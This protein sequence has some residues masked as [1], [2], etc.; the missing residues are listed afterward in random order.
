MP[1]KQ[2][3]MGWGLGALLAL[4]L[5]G[6][7]GGLVPATPTAPSL[8]DPIT[9]QATA[10][11]TLGFLQARAILIY[12]QNGWVHITEAVTHDLDRDLYTTLADGTPVP[13]NHVLDTWANITGARLVT[14]QV[15]FLH[16]EAGQLLQTSV[17]SEGKKWNSATQT[18]ESTD[19]GP[20]GAFDRG[21]GASIPDYVRAGAA[22]SQTAG[23]LDGAATIEIVVDYSFDK[24]SKYED[25]T[26][27]VAGQFIRAIYDPM[28]GQL[29]QLNWH[30][31]LADG[32][33][34]AYGVWN[35]TLEANVSPP[36]EVLEAL[37]VIG[38]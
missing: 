6:C 29:R 18:T 7:G 11:E 34:R 38:P 23:T 28:G 20:A 27:E 24:P 19:S 1:R 17:I 13:L 21:F 3:W 25:Y 37:K 35:V 14:Q 22:V 5:A 15:I 9:M 31:R 16:D 4:T 2:R 36:D 33:E 30:M 26:Q 10:L 32:S 12:G 8:S